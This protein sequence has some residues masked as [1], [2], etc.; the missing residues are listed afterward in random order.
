MDLIFHQEKGSHFTIEVGYFDTVL[1]IKEK[2]QKLR[3]IP[4]AAQTLVFAGEV[5]PDDLDV[6]HSDILHNSHIRLLV[7]CSEGINGHESPVRSPPAAAARKPIRVFLKFRGSDK[8]GISLEMD[9]CDTIRTLKE[10]INKETGGTPAAGRQITVY[11]NGTELLDGRTLGDYELA[12]D[13]EIEVGAKV[14]PSPATSSGSSGN[15]SGSGTKKLLRVMVMSKCGTKKFAVDVNPADNVGEL[16][17]ELERLKEEQ[18]LE[19]PEEGYFFIYKQNVMDDDRSFRWHS[20]GQSE[21]IE[22]FNGSV[23]GGN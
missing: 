9:V 17:K 11:V 23:S 3:R 16:R 4:A 7:S 10:R 19:L 20:V 18:D 2:I 5:L 6:H 1:E 21:T 15:A 8:P 22:I 13:S 12:Q 14:K